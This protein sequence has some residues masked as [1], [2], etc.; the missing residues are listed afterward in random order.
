[1]PFNSAKACAPFA[2]FFGHSVFV[3]SGLVSWMGNQS[4]VANTDGLTVDLFQ[5]CFLY[6][7]S[8]V[9]EGRDWIYPI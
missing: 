1:M 6:N 8:Y 4:E 5:F 9:K 7:G 3:L 2:V